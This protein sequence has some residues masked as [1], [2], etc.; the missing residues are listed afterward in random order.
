MRVPEREHP[1]VGR[2]EPVSV[3]VPRH[4]HV[5]HGRDE[6][7]AAGRTME[8]RVT[9]GEDAAVLSEQD[10]AVAGGRC[11]HAD[12]VAVEVPPVH[13]TMELRVAERVDGAVGSDQPVAATRRRARPRHDR[14][15]VRDVRQVSVE[16]GA[17]EGAHASVRRHDPIPVALRAVVAAGL[18]R[19]NRRPRI[20]QS[21]A[22]GVV[23]TG[24]TEITSRRLERALDVGSRQ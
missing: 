18:E 22:E 12:D 8:L 24:C 3:A 6:L 13:G 21:V 14:L 9:E 16:G 20:D 7:P 15:R 5:E 4:R 19:G 23:T 11:R 17:A 1:A 10:V 2:D